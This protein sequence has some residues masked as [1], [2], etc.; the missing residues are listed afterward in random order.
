MSVFAGFQQKMS[1]MAE[2][3]LLRD[4]RKMQNNPPEGISGAPAENNIFQW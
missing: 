4:F 1:K 2:R 3:R